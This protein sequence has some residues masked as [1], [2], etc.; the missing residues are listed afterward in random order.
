LETLDNPAKHGTHL[1]VR[2]RESG[3][4]LGSGTECT[5]VSCRRNA[6]GAR[7]AIPPFNRVTNQGNDEL[8]TH[9]AVSNGHISGECPVIE[10]VSDRLLR[11]PS[12]P[13]RP[14]TTR[15]A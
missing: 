1:L 5:G 10:D 8:Y 9:H 14:R 2:K 4:V 7:A 3:R 11:L 13:I 6:T 15:R 12:T